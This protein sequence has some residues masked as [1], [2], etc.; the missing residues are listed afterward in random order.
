MI[1][2]GKK[3]FTKMK[4]KIKSKLVYN[5]IWKHI[6]YVKIIGFLFDILLSL[7]TRVDDLFSI[8]KIQS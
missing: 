4:I 8:L 3:L 2:K 6:L 7:K 1:K 5:K